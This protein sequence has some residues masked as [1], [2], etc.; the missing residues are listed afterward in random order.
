MTII[1]HSSSTSLS[2]LLPLSCAFVVLPFSPALTLS[3]HFSFH[4]EKTPKQ[5]LSLSNTILSACVSFRQ[6][7]LEEWKN[8]HSQFRVY[9]QASFVIC[10]VDK[11]R[12]KVSTSP[13]ICFMHPFVLSFWYFTN[14]IVGK[15][16]CNVDIYA[17]S[18]FFFPL[19]S[20]F[21]YNGKWKLGQCHHFLFPCILQLPCSFVSG[22][23]TLRLI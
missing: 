19:I 8:W 14:L 13:Y 9:P 17:I 22:P 5:H 11:S 7:S 23:F 16:H 21:Y 2:A 1:S 15:T 3:T 6:V 10:L 4:F 20:R 18:C 12:E